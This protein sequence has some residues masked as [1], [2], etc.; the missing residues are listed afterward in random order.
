MRYRFQWS[1]RSGWGT[2]AEGDEH[3]FEPAVAEAIN[4]DSPGVL[5]PVAVEVE[6]VPA[7]ALER[8]VD[9]PPQDRMR[10]GPDRKRG[11]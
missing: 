7:P 8:A 1:Y 6:F 11:R 10:R 9:A 5:V 3:D 2:W 4:R